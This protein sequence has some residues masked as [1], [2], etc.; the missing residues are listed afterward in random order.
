[1]KKHICNILV[2]ALVLLLCA[3]KEDKATQRILGAGDCQTCYGWS[4]NN[5]EASTTNN[6]Y[7]GRNSFS[8]KTTIAGELSFSYAEMTKYTDYQRLTVYVGDKMYFESGATGSSYTSAS[9]G[10]VQK[11]EDVTFYGRRYHVKDIKI[12]GEAGSALPESPEDD[13]EHQWDF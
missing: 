10:T 4:W 2:Y 5:G 3:C 6:D 12:V 13:P 9:L 8:F 1:M 7:D 11:G